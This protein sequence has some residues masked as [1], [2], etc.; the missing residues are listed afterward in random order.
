MTNLTSCSLDCASSCEDLDTFGT[1]T[2]VGYRTKLD[3]VRTELAAV[4][5]ELAVA[6][7]Q[8]AAVR[9]GLAVVRTQLIL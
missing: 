5:T 6:S 7:T 4:W 3:L 2:L 1:T 9:T 8:L